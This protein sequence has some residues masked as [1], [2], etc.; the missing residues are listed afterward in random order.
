MMN[1]PVLDQQFDQ[2]L[3][4]LLA[5]QLHAAGALGQ[6]GAGLHAWLQARALPPFLGRWLDASLDFLVAAQYL[7]LEHGAHRFGPA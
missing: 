7:R 5:H 4:R 2:S 1:D 3:C 6:S